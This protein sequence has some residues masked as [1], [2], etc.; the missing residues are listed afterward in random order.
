MLI[1]VD[2]YIQSQAHFRST[3]PKVLWKQPGFLTEHQMVSVLTQLCAH[4]RLI[5]YRFMHRHNQ[6]KSLIQSLT[7]WDRVAFT[8]TDKCNYSRASAHA[9]GSMQ[10]VYYLPVSTPRPW[11]QWLSCI[12]TDDAY[13]LTSQMRSRWSAG[14]RNTQW[15]RT[16]HLGQSTKDSNSSSKSINDE[17]W[18]EA[19][20]A[21]IVA[22]TN[23]GGAGGA[24]CSAYLSVHSPSSEV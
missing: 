3:A 15:V 6:S 10:A 5:L 22:W 12:S 1:S 8:S 18:K 14:P 17:C 7:E 21:W 13:C 19:S 24:Q 2:N 23:N 9:L 4:G 11:C 16:R 20:S